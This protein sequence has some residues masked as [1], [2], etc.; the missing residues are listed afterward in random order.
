MATMKNDDST[1][2]GSDVKTVDHSYNS[3]GDI[4]CYSYSGKSLDS[5]LKN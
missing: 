3:C 1:N 4:K 5:L 2:A